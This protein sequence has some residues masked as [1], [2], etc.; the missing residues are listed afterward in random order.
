MSSSSS[1][2]W[3]QQNQHPTFNIASASSCASSRKSSTHLAPEFYSNCNLDQFGGGMTPRLGLSEFDAMRQSGANVAAAGGGFGATP[4]R[5][6]SMGAADD[7]ARKKPDVLIDHRKCNSVDNTTPPNSAKSAGG[8]MCDLFL[9]FFLFLEWL[10]F[11]YFRSVTSALCAA[12]VG[13]YGL[14]PLRR[15]LLSDQPPPPASSSSLS[16]TSGN[17]G[18]QTKIR[19]S[20][21]SSCLDNLV[22]NSA[23]ED[24]GSNL[25]SV[26]RLRANSVEL[27][28]KVSLNSKRKSWQVL[29][30]EKNWLIKE[31]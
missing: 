2:F 9:D 6:I 12:T 3:P 16:L 4:F 7:G 18:L 21:S 27:L 31:F 15:E 13:M 30:Y 29:I 11:R 19:D 14:S 22:E 23:I 17:L 24:A 5:R 1:S 20:H 10:F 26:E 25:G 28:R 8:K